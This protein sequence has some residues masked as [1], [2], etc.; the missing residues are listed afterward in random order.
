MRESLRNLYRHRALVEVLTAREV[1]ARYRGSVLGFLWSLINPLLMLGMYTVVFQLLLPNR[2][3]ST[4]PYAIF[5]FAGLLPWNWLAGSLTDA[6]SSLP[7]HGALLRKILFPAEILP[8]VS[9]LAQAIHF[10]L[11]LPILLVALVAGGLGAFGQTGSSMHVG[12]PILQVPLLLLVECVL[13]FGVAYF[14]SAL[15]VHFRDIK[16]LLSTALS[17]A[18]F[19]TP[20]LYTLA[21]IKS[22]R[23]VS[24]LRLNPL[25][26]L[27]SAWQDALFYG[28]WIPARSWA[29]LVIGSLAAFAA[30]YRVFD[31]LRDSLPE[32]V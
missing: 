7:T 22:P 23:L 31:Q 18:F 32:A 5:L 10:L 21:D 3:V 8:T 26:F 1:K 20:I 14:L 4:R 29:I 25:A 6:A 30:G 9:V 11:A 17:L 12:L 13:L 28:R 27:F 24:L 19:A 16:D 2:A 15:T